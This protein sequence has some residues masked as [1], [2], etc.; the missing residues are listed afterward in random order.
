[1]FCV[2]RDPKKTE[3]PASL[4]GKC[5]VRLIR[6]VLSA[7]EVCFFFNSRSPAAAR[8]TPVKEHPVQQ[9]GLLVDT[10]KL[11]MDNC[12]YTGNM[13]LVDAVLAF[14]VLYSDLKTPG[15]IN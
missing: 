11:D 2:R 8:F 15:L 9:C 1:M 5:W 3:K 14:V 12:V 4:C 10:D 13:V 6:S 7:K